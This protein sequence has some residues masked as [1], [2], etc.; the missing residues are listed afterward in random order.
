MCSCVCLV[1]YLFISR[2][3][4]LRAASEGLTICHTA[5]PKVTA[6]RMTGVTSLL[7]NFLFPSMRPQAS[8]MD[9]ADG[10][11]LRG[12]AVGAPVP[13]VLVVSAVPVTLHNILLS[14]IAR[15]LVTHE[16]AGKQT[17]TGNEEERWRLNMKSCVEGHEKVF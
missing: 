4:K 3:W 5:P 8:L 16:A 13:P 12:L 10:L 11:D 9:S 6:A 1:F 17:M 7:P 14:S 2:K 15:V